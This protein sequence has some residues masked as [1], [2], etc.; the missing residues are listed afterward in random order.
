V[1]RNEIAHSVPADTRA[2]AVTAADQLPSSVLQAA[3]EAFR[4][5]LQ[6]AA[7]TTLRVI[8]AVAILAAVLVRGRSDRAAKGGA[9]ARRFRRDPRSAV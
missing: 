2:Q 5:G 3:T 7:G 4:H 1:Y 6:I 9:A 8:A